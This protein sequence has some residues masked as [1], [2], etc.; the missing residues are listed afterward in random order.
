MQWEYRN[1]K[2]KNPSPRLVDLWSKKAKVKNNE[3]IIDFLLDIRGYQTIKDKDNFLNPPNP[4]D[5]TTK[6]FGIDSKE[7][8]KAILRIK[9]AVDNDEHIIIYGDY[10]VDGVS[11]TAILWETLYQLTP[12]VLPYLPER[13][14]E[15]Y[16]FNLESVK[17]QKTMNNKLGVIITVDQGITAGDKIAQVKKELGIDVIVCDH[18]ELPNNPPKCVALIHTVKVCAAGIAWI[19]SQEILRYFDSKI[20]VDDKLELAALATIADLEPLTGINR[21]LVKFGLEELNKTKRPGLLSLIKQ[22]G[23]ELGKIGTYEIGYIIAP[24]IN[25]MGRMAHAIDALRLLCTRQEEKALN[26]ALVLDQTNRDRQSLMEE[27]FQHSRSLFLEQN[28]LDSLPKFILVAHESYQEGVIGLAAGKLTEEFHRPSVVIS[29]GEKYSKASARSISGFNIIE[30]LREQMDLLVDVGGHPMA[31]GFTIE[32]GK[33]DQLKERLIKTAFEKISDDMMQKTLMVDLPI[34][35]EMISKQLYE[36]IQQM[37]PFGIGNP[38]PIFSS[39]GLIK[40]CRTVGSDA[41]HLKLMIGDT[42]SKFS[43]SAI[44]FNFGKICNELLSINQIEFAYN[45][46]LNTYNGNSNIELKIR[47]FK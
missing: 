18:H 31:A 15:G 35:L 46:I 20:G 26:L 12:N 37:A 41:K 33:I 32:T 47:D 19:F 4:R 6:D 11:G 2:V 39:V 43:F 27:I 34:S 28:Q 21:S 25:A 45:L 13:I 36:Q 38:E 1:N 22:S 10:D 7:V 23:I 9:Q 24:R 17:K 3:N 29:I 8:K 5:L 40:N 30:I 16:G 44:A 14:S 42:D